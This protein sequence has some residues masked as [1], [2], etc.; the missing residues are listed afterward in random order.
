MI[1][2]MARK[3]IAWTLRACGYG[4]LLV[5]VFL[6]PSS[7]HPDTKLSFSTPLHWAAANGQ[8]RLAERLIS[9]GASASAPDSWG[10]SPLH[11]AVRHRDV[12]EL[13]IAKGASVNSRDRF[14][15]TPLHLAVPYRDV[16][17]LLLASGAD[18]TAR[19]FFGK[20]PLELCLARGDSPYN[21]GVAEL[22]IAAGAAK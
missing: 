3:V 8:A 9:N 14:Q 5:A 2:V 7:A 17:E 4:V 21:V 19:N 15:N 16:V 20:T 11:L 12:V 18:V 13:L 6:I 1:W 22:L 10:R